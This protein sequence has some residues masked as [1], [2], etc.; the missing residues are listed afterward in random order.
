MK[1]FGKYIAVN[2]RIYMLMVASQMAAS[3]ALDIHRFLDSF[4]LFSKPDKYPEPV[5]TWEE[6][7][8]PDSSFAAKFVETPKYISREA[9]YKYN[10]VNLFMLGLQIGILCLWQIDEIYCNGLSLSDTTHA[11]D[12]VDFLVTADGSEIISSG[13]EE[14]DGFRVRTIKTRVPVYDVIGYFRV[15]YMGNRIVVLSC[16]EHPDKQFQGMHKTFFDSFRFIED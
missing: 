2:D 9:S 14:V 6:Y 16:S 4:K 7:Y 12:L 5:Y 15:Y 11:N 10:K 13:Y 1:I 8:P 3:E